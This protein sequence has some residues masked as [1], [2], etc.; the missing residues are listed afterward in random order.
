MAENRIGVK[1]ASAFTAQW[2]F[3]CAEVDARGVTVTVSRFGRFALSD[4]ER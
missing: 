1:R 3:S 2:C 4:G